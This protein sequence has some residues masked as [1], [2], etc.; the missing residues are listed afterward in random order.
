[1]LSQL[2]EES[3]YFL[4]WQKFIVGA[5]FDFPRSFSRWILLLSMVAILLIVDADFGMITGSFT[6]G[7]EIGQRVDGRCRG[8][9]CCSIIW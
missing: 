5:M 1:M 3:D 4:N 8:S 9:Y 7:V 2:G 6:T